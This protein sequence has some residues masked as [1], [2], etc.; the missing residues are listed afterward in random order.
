MKRYSPPT[1]RRLRGA[2]LSRARGAFKV[3]FETHVEFDPTMASNRQFSAIVEQVVER[4]RAGGAST[5]QTLAAYRDPPRSTGAPDLTDSGALLDSLTV[6]KVKRKKGKA[7]AE[8][9][10]PNTP[11]PRSRLSHAELALIH[12]TGRGRVTA[13]PFVGLTAEQV[14]KVASAVAAVA[15][16][17]EKRGPPKD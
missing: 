3:K 16:A 13:R 9:G 17:R 5:G 12:H 15:I 8:I 7:S 10:F 2:Q 4:T 14:R 1:L 11:H 6:L